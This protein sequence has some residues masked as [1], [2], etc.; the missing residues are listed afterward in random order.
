MAKKDIIRR[1]KGEVIKE[2][3]IENKQEGLKKEN[4][5]IPLILILLCLFVIM[6]I[7]VS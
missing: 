6:L 7:V 1:R 4:L 2:A 5:W 3:I